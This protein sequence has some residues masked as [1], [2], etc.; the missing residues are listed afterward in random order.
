[1]DE[2]D[3][4]PRIAELRAADVVGVARAHADDLDAVDVLAFPRRGDHHHLV[5]LLDEVA[6]ELV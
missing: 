2:L 1:V 4:S 6:R 3:D 5:A